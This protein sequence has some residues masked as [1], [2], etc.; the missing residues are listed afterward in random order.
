MRPFLHSPS[1]LSLL[2]LAFDVSNDSK[3]LIIGFFQYYSDAMYPIE[4]FFDFVVDQNEWAH[5][6]FRDPAYLQCTIFMASS[7]RALMERRAITPNTYSHLRDAIARL[8]TQLSSD[9]ANVIL[10]DSTI[11]AVTMLTMFSCIIN[12]H[13]AAKAHIAGLQQMVGLRGGLQNFT[14]NP[15]LYLQLGRLADPRTLPIFHELQYYTSLVNDAQTTR[16]RRS[17][18]EFH[19]V[20]CSFQYR[21]LQLQGAFQDPLSECLR[22]AML[23]F[24]ITT[25]QFPGTKARYPYLAD[26]LR[27]SC[28]ALRV[29]LSVG[30]GDEVRELVRWVLIVGAISVFDLGVRAEV[31]WMGEM[32]MDVDVEY[33]EWEE[34]RARLKQILWIDVLQDRIGRAAF[35]EWNKYV[36]S[37]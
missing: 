10:R 14:N 12:D 23:A 34:A 9:D 19:A 15:K 22:L 7:A 35:E 18:H 25:F 20:I 27:A 28:L 32:W 1:N 24:L 16:Q 3:T 36:S 11:A 5:W 30:V 37:S 2:R 13:A 6:L 4:L 17:I 31:E 21:L 29:G 8:N 33:V 26:C